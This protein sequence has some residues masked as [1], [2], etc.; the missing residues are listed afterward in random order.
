M[1][2][3]RLRDKLFVVI[4]VPAALLG[5]YVYFWRI[6]HQEKLKTANEALAKL[7]TP[8]NH[9]AERQKL[10]KLVADTTA[11]FE[12]ENKLTVPE[13][14]IA[15][16]AGDTVA[17]RERAVLDILREAG[18]RVV[19]TEIDNSEGGGARGGGVLRATALR[20]SPRGRRYRLEG[21]YAAVSQALALLTE[22]KCAVIAERL[23]MTKG[24]SWTLL[25]WF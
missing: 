1:T 17:A 6:P 16:N 18:L 9:A 23:E 11:E 10:E 13:T 5:S 21:S 22:R 19:S 12:A 7:M 15:A 4:V 3:L 8:E 14:K 20:P 25:L 2:A 24:E